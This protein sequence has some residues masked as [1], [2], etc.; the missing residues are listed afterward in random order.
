MPD[1]IKPDTQALNQVS[2]KAKSVLTVKKDSLRRIDR[3][4]LESPKGGLMAA[5]VA[6]T[7]CSQ[8]GGRN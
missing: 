4:K 6:G 5:D 3:G 2:D 8:G 1:K 7:V